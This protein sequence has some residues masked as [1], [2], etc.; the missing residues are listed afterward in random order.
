MTN[1]ATQPEQTL[2]PEEAVEQAQ[3]APYS[4]PRLQRISEADALLEVLGPAQAFYRGSGI[5]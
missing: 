3:P 5:P 1:V 4:P 2:R